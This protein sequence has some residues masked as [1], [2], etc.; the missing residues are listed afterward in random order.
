MKL[1]KDRPTLA[2]EKISASD[3]IV[4]IVVRDLMA[5][6]STE[7]IIGIPSGCSLIELLKLR[8]LSKEAQQI[9]PKLFRTQIIK[10]VE[11]LVKVKKA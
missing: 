6:D 8:G 11:K 10:E 2:S 3:S 5:L 9:S 1:V 4:K 7:E